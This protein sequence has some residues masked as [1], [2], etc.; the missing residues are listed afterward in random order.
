[1]I[2]N[3]AVY[4]MT[5]KAKKKNK[6]KKPMFKTQTLYQPVELINLYVSK[7]QVHY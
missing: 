2:R 5:V 7:K 6:K 4:E 3:Y 1:M